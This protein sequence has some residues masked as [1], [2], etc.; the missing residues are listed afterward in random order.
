[1]QVESNRCKK[2]QRIDLCYSI[3]KV[4]NIRWRIFLPGLLVVI[5]LL[6]ALVIFGMDLTGIQP[7]EPR[8]AK[9]HSNV[10]RRSRVFKRKIRKPNYKSWGRLHPSSEIKPRYRFSGGRT[11]VKFVI[12]VPT[13]LRPRTNYVLP[14]V[15]SLIQQMTPKQ[16]DNC[17]IVIYVGETKLQFAKYIVKTLHVNH[18]E[19][20]RAGLI[21]VIA[22]PLN[23]YPNFSR[24]HITLHDDPKRVYWRT[25]QNLDYIYLMSYARSKGSYY[26]QL[27]DDVKSNKGFLDYIEKF[28]ILHGNFRFAHQ[29]DW[30][31][32]SF[33]DLGFIGKLFP[34]SVLNSFVAYL[35]LF[36]NDQP[37]DWLLQSFV[38]LQSCRWDSIADPNC[39]MDYE[40]RL[41]RAGQ[42]QF[43]HMG[44]LSSLAEKLQYRK[45]GFFNHNL[46]RQ[47]M[48]HLRQPFN[49][50]AS[51]RNALL[52]Q[53][54]DLKSG[55]TFI[56][57][58]M[59][60]MPKMVKY[61]IK[62][63]FK[64]TQIRIRNAKDT[65]INLAEFNVHLVKESPTL[66]KNSSA[67][68]ECGF[69]LCH[70]VLGHD[71]KD[72]NK[73]ELPYNYMYYYIKEE[74][75]GL[76]WFRRFLWASNGSVNHKL[77]SSSPHL[78]LVCLQLI[79]LF[80]S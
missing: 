23:Y 1:M 57:I 21:D 43:Q 26:L 13:V 72:L 3:M 51:H 79:I 77:M 46:G 20:M 24:L 35:Q 29:P 74:P 78:I 71:E 16:R 41:I 19:H 68:E 37:I 53:D 25:K 10:E 65:A 50:I 49:L 32:I 80:I 34:T 70:T 40:S 66:E 4:I 22:P 59:P 12:G 31:A 63:Q 30:I 8:V 56:W 27:E 47:R 39:Q 7:V 6:S 15:Y 76:N 11:A 42:S 67:T 44:E 54:L 75:D 55:E 18:S 60:Q 48:Q 61:L 52:K 38:T 73:E 58:Y 62:N 69:V 45:D 5:Y 17:L 9:N 14:T 64:N 33:S 2:S 28:A 36:F